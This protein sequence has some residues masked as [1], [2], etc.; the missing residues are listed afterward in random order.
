VG[1]LEHASNCVQV[2][3][4]VPIGNSLVT[5][6]F[7]PNWNKFAPTGSYPILAQGFYDLNDNVL[8]GFGEAHWIGRAIA[9]SGVSGRTGAIG[10]I[11][12]GGGAL[13]TG[14][15]NDAARGDF[16]AII[17]MLAAYVGGDRNRILMLGGS[18]GGSTALT[19]AS[20][21]APSYNYK[22]TYVLAWVP[23]TKTGTH[24]SLASATTP[25]LFGGGAGFNNGWVPGW[26]YP[27]YGKPS[28]VG[29][30][31]LQANLQTLVGTT[32]PA[33]ADANFAPIS[34][35]FVAGLVAAGTQV[36][37]A[38][39]S[40]DEYIPFGTQAEY[41]F[42]LRAWG[43]PVEAHVAMRGGHTRLGALNAQIRIE[44]ALFSYVQPGAPVAWRMAETGLESIRYYA[45][46]RTTQQVDLVGYS[47]I[48]F[49]F[50]LEVPYRVWSGMPIVIM[51]TGEPGT[52]VTITGYNGATLVASFP[53]NIG[54][55]R[56][57][58][59]TAGSEYLG[60]ITLSY[61]VTIQKPG[62]APQAMNMSN[63]PGHS[64]VPM[65]TEVLPGPPP[66][67]WGHAQ[68]YPYFQNPY[69]FGKWTQ[70]NWGISEY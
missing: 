43:V 64:M 38:F 56:L 25:M 59:I 16:A 18:R 11:W 24:F 70:T 23:G 30:S 47:N 13:G 69:K 57:C 37:L 15:I 62:Q 35:R 5:I 39:G 66:T 8:G 20:N 49:P 34:D 41:L 27:A 40:H 44:N 29:L 60:G 54:P 7:P 42:K 33:W 12:N 3:H 14:T 46:N 21:P 10:V 19:I 58:T 52:A 26:T 65:T 36:V 67:S 53:C 45:V 48:Q 68:M 55:T 32:D 9:Q 2:L 1:K 28:L 4:G 61:Q 63:V 22:V 31:A 6:M 51:A 17:D 50:T